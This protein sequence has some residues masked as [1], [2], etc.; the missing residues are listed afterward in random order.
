L[1]KCVDAQFGFGEAAAAG[2]V[3]GGLPIVPKRFTTPG[4]SPATSF[5]GYSLPRGPTFK[6]PRW[7]PTARHP[8]S[9][10]RHLGRFAGRWIPWLSGGL[11]AQD[12]HQI[13]KCYIKCRE[14]E[15]GPDASR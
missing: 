1:C 7:A 11:L 13:R 10:T 2:G 9:T 5:L 15:C 4:S 12:G 8:F 3:A 14:G 6:K